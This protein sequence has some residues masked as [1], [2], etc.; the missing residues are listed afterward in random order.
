MKAI[1]VIMAIAAE[2]E[3]RPGEDPSRP[4]AASLSGHGMLGRPSRAEPPCRV[5]ASASAAPADRQQDQEQDERL[6]GRVAHLVGLERGLVDV[7]HQRLGALSGPPAPL[8][9]ML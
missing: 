7:E 1:G 8:S 3:Q 4:E 9:V 5:T 6:R 2:R